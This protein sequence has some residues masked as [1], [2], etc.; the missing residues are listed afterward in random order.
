MRYG[1]EFPN[2]GVC[3]DPCLLAEFAA[4]AEAAGWDGVFLEDYIIFHDNPTGPTCDPAVALAAMA[5]R[6]TRVRLGTLVTPLARR[7]PWKLAREFATLDHLSNGRVVLGA[8]L[9]VGTEASFSAFGEE[10]DNRRRSALLDEALELVAGFWTGQPVSMNGVG[11][12]V[13][14]ATLQPPSVQT[15]R[16]PIWVGGGWPK[17]GFMRRAARWDGVVPYVHSDDWSWR[18]FTPEEV[19]QLR[20]TLLAERDPSAPFDIV[21][22]GR[23][24]RDDWEQE[25]DLIASVAEAG[26][27]WWME[28]NSAADEATMRECITR[29][30]LR[31]A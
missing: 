15:P 25:R 21:I 8:G 26:A 27:T 3:G 6:T 31:I 12:H 24:R 18:D 10:Q 13:D 22:G 23:S 17:L 14:R 11:Y 9:G 16:I 1:I 29:G 5:L 4:L 28:Y 2:A 30:P 19:R 20:A 7:R